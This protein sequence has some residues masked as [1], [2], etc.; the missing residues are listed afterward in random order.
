M[1]D[2]TAAE[3]LISSNK[4]DVMKVRSRDG[5]TV[6]TVHS[7]MI[8]KRTGQTSYA[9]LS[10]GGFLGLGKAYYPLPFEL[11]TFVPATDSYAITIDARVIE[12]G[13]SWASTPPAFDQAYADRVASYYGVA[14]QDLAI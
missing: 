11:M 5:Q 1:T 6:G 3:L 7:Y 8:N 2:Q 12:G 4:P 13:P 9:V 10:I 14:R